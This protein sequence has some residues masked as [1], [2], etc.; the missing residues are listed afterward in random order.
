MLGEV[1]IHI[2]KASD[3]ADTPY[4]MFRVNRLCADAALC[5]YGTAV[6]ARLGGIEMVD[7]LH[8]G[9]KKYIK[10]IN[11]ESKFCISYVKLAYFTSPPRLNSD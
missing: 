1:V 11:D 2:S 3:K 8:T 9:K 6:Q 5:V 4:L 10:I 7:K